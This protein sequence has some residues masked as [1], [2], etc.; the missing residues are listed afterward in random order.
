M[1][2]ELNPYVLLAKIG[3]AIAL[4][5]AVWFH[6]HKVGENAVQA[7]WDASRV[8][9]AE[10]TA[11]L[12]LE[13]SLEMDAVRKRQDAINVQV[14]RDFE[15]KLDEIGKS[16][17]AELDRVRKSGGLR[18]PGSICPGSTSTGT[19]TTSPSGSNETGPAT[20]ILPEQVTEGLFNLVEEADKVTEQ[21]RACQG[22]IR[23]QGFHQP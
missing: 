22:W 1:A 23:Q 5:I 6:G 4:L 16:H 8:A 9:L 13:H 2:M 12:V 19:Q 3:A 21:L 15:G 17:A 14:S 10:Q 18:L 20:V 11:K 7:D